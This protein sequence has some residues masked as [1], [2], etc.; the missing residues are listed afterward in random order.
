VKVRHYF[1]PENSLRPLYL[2]L[3]SPATSCAEVQYV[4]S[5]V[6]VGHE[7]GRTSFLRPGA[8]ERVNLG[9]LDA[10]PQV[11]FVSAVGKI[12]GCNTG[13]M[14]EWFVDVEVTSKEK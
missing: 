4:V 7:I 5:G 11:I 12:G 1:L 3:T 14:L 2:S 6:R 13:R 9:K 8:N 10:G